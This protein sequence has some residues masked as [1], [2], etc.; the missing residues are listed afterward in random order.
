M[1]PVQVVPALDE[2]EDRG[3]GGGPG[4][5]GLVVEHSRLMVA[6]NDSASALSQHWPVRPTDKRDA[7]LVGQGGVLGAGVLAA[8]VGVEDHPGCGRAGGDGVGQGVGDQVGAQVVGQGPADDPAGGEVDDGGQVQPAL[9]GRD[10]GD[11]AAPAGVDR[12]GVGREV[13][14]DQVR[15]GRRRPGRGSW[16]AASG[17]GARPRSPA[18]R[19]SRATRLRPVPMPSSAQ[20]GVDPRGAVGAL[21]LGVDRR[22][23]LGQLGVGD[24]RRAEGCR[25]RWA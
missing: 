4:G 24:A 8:A 20:L 11:V 13:A 22:D 25:L 19:I 3:A 15:P 10:V 7:E 14:A 6:K 21:G 12:R 1:Q 18:A 9:P 17:C 5:P 23:L 2:V 16:S